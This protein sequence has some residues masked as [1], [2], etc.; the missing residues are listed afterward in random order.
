MNII[1]NQNVAFR[2]PNSLRERLQT[3]ADENDLRVSAVIR[4]ACADWLKLRAAETS[5]RPSRPQRAYTRM[6]T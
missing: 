1:H 4:N 5:S 3:Y 6:L 2:C